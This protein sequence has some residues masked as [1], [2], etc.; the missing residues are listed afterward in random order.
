MKLCKQL[1]VTV[2]VLGI[3]V[4][5]THTAL[6]GDAG[7]SAGFCR[8]DT[9][10]PAAVITSGNALIEVTNFNAT[11][12][13][14]DATLQ[15]NFLGQDFFFRG[16]FDLVP[17][18]DPFE[19]A[20]ALLDPSA[21]GSDILTSLGF[22]PGQKTMVLTNKSITQTDFLKVVPN[23]S[24]ERRSTVA[25]ITIYIVDKNPEDITGDVLAR[26]WVGL[27]NS[28]DVGTNFDFKAEV[29]KNGALVP[30]STGQA[31]YEVGGSSGFDHAK[32]T[33]FPLQPTVTF[34]SGNTVSVK[35]SV[36]ITC[37]GGSHG[38]GTARLW[39]NDSAADS[40]LTAPVGGSPHDFFLLTPPALGNAAGP[41][42]KKTSDVFVNSNAACP[43]RPFTSF[44]TWSGVAP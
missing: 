37:A 15:L 5:S 17:M 8:V 30:D 19:L 27:K 13:N 25:D 33:V 26:M 2:G 22:N 36:R 18:A 23:S 14:V 28:D 4:G 10:P 11:T 43:G 38:S 12:G 24:P 29:F 39:F 34:S 42:P 41:G 7:G 6:A 9:K 44:G 3:L 21:L 1:I 35:L 16:H 40:K 32:L 20:C 31:T